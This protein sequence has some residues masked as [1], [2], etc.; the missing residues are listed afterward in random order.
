MADEESHEV[1]STLSF[2][3]TEGDS[4]LH[5]AAFRMTV[6]EKMIQNSEFRAQN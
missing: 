1:L 2:A 5:F 3:K 4:S 6:M